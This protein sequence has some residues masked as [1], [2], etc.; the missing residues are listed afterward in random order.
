M[1]GGRRG[2]LA[3]EFLLSS[4]RSCL[5]GVEAGAGLC[6]ATSALARSSL[7]TPAPSLDLDITHVDMA[8]TGRHESDQSQTGFVCRVCGID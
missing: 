2:L 6:C 5:A 7:L 1:S 8:D 3:L 4:L